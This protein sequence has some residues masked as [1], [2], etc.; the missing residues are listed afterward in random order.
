MLFTKKLA[1][2]RT[3][4]AYD[5]LQVTVRKLGLCFILLHIPL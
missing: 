3:C 1:S 4:I 5:Y 2:G